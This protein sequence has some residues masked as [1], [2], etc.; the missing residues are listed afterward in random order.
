MGPVGHYPLDSGLR[1]KRHKP[2]AP[3][4]ALVVLVCRAGQAAA[5]QGGQQQGTS[6]IVRLT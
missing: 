1:L 2:K 3:V 6:G 5:G 4:L